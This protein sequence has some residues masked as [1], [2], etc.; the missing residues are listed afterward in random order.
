MFWKVCSM[1][2][3]KQMNVLLTAETSGTGTFCHLTMFNSY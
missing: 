2:R 3:D 1:A